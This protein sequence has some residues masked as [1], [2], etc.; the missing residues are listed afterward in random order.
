M[1][2]PTY[3]D[4]VDLLK[5]GSTLEAQEKIMELREGSL[6]L[7]EENIKL[8]DKIKELEA[9]IKLK[10]EVIWVAPSYWVQEGVN[11]DGPFCQSCFDTERKLIRLQEGNARGKWHCTVCNNTFKDGTYTPPEINIRRSF[12]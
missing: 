2:I 12:P 3:K 6:E 10:E 8:K 4:I 7:Q 5:K 9:A 1:A 11:K